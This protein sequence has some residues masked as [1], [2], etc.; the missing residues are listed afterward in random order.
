ME[1]GK[2]PGRASRGCGSARE[3]A[4]AWMKESSKGSLDFG[5]EGA[6]GTGLEIDRLAGGEITKEDCGVGPLEV[7]AV[8]DGE[9]GIAAWKKRRHGE[10]A[11]GI[12]LVAVV[13]R[14]VVAG[15]L[16]NEKNHS[17]SYRLSVFQGEA[18]KRA[19]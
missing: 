7:P 8:F 5:V 11:V 19:S 17:A 3:E 15:I 10:R 4:Y 13:E 1:N 14:H 18:G 2:S 9:E 6:G 16:G 12:A